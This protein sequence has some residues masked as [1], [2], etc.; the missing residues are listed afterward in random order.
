MLRDLSIVISAVA[1]YFAPLGYFAF[2]AFGYES[3]PWAWGFLI[4]WA[5]LGT[6][7]TIY[8]WNAYEYVEDGE[9]LSFE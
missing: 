5:L 9:E 2:W 8:T 4:G 6:L 7:F 3:S 1:C